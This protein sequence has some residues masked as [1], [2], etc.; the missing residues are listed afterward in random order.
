MA[1]PDR[2]VEITEFAQ[3]GG[4]VKARRDHIRILVE[5]GTIAVDGIAEPLALLLD[6]AQAKQYLGVARS[7]Q[8]GG[9]QD[10]DRL[11]VRPGMGECECM[12][13]AALDIAGI[14]RRRLRKLGKRFR[15][16][17]EPGQ[18]FAECRPVVRVVRRKIDGAPPGLDRRVIHGPAH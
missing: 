6:I 18:A 15:M 3:A 12:R 2:T 7:R 4:Q 13:N 8:D 17:S 5:R 14:E 16:T 9:V 1:L 11:V 10:F